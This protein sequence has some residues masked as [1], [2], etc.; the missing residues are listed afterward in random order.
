MRR[1]PTTRFGALA[2]TWVASVAACVPIVVLAAGARATAAPAGDDAV[3]AFVVSGV[4]NGHGRG[5][6]Q[7]GSFG[8][9]LAG[10]TYGEILEAYYGNTEAGSRAGAT[11][12][13][14]L[15]GW[16]GA[17]TVGVISSTGAAMWNGVGYRSLMAIETSAGT[18]DVYGSTTDQGCPTQANLVVPHVHLERG[19]SGTEVA[20]MQ[21]VL[22]ALGHSPGAIDGSFGEMTEAAVRSFQAAE[23]LADTG[24]WDTATYTRAQERVDALGS[25]AVAWGSLATGVVG[26]VQFTTT[27]SSTGAAGEQLGLCKGDGGVVHYRGAI[28]VHHTDAGNRV[29]NSVGIDAY[30]RGVVPRESPGYWGDGGEGKGMHSLRAQSVAA[31][32]YA[33]TQARYGSV[34]G[35]CDTASCQVYGGAATRQSATSGWRSVEHVNTDQAIADTAGEVRVWPDGPQAG[36]VVSTEFSASNGP[37]TAGGSFPAVDDPFDDHPDNPL[38]RWTRIIDA[39]RLA[40]VYDLSR[41]DAVRTAPQPSSPYQGIWANEV[42]LGD[43]RTVSAWDFRNAFALPAPGFELTPITRDVS[44]AATFAYIGDSVG[45]GIAGAESSPLRV[46][47]E[48]VHGGQ[49]WDSRG[50]RATNEGAQVAAT[51]PE[52]TNL[53]VVELGYNDSPSQMPGRI[54]AVM[55]ALRDR[56]VDRVMWVTVSERRANYDYESTNAAIR[57][58]ESRWAELDVLEWGAASAHAA[59][60][61]WYADD[62]VHLT[63]TGNAEFSLFLRGHILGGTARPVAADGVYRVPVLGLGGVPAGDT[64]G[65]AGVGGVALNVTAVNPAGP[66]WLRVWDCAAAEPDTSSVNFM[67]AGAVEPNA[68]VVPLDPDTTEVCVRAKVRTHVIVDVAGYFPAEPAVLQS[69]AGRVIDTRDEALPRVPAGG[70]LRVQVLGAAGVPTAPT[71][72]EAGVAGVA[73]NV[74]A[75]DTGGPGWLRVWDCAAAEPDTSSVNYTTAGAAE[76]NAVIVPFDPVSSGEVCVKSLVESDVIV[77]LAGWF[78]A[79]V[80]LA[81][82]RVIDTRLSEPVPGQGVLRVPVLGVAGVPAGATAGEA[83]VAGV[84]LNVT[85]VDTSAAG[86]LRVWDCAR[87]E[88]DTSS[89]NYMAAGAVEPNAVVVPFDPA[90]SGEVCVK[91]LVGAHVIVD[92]AGWFD[93]GVAPAA[94][95]I[96]DTRYGIGPL[97]D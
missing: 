79:G 48:G 69:A 74:T 7:W 37:R 55:Q 73:L 20:Q 2:I 32:S 21:R 59:A 42:V 71:A 62:G 18:F 28:E 39:D 92:L 83:G 50:G 46:L 38:H 26:P 9:A 30:L 85:A 96:A 78:S 80:R 14:R 58:A 93:A 53:A 12:R 8:R 88:P 54:D 45:E 43:G 44:S 97:P 15:T 66:G 13:V 5:L 95:R 3:V 64:A 90:G 87:P 11:V 31:R 67:A 94:G 89:V 72:G 23:G 86:W 24:Q 57:A 51:V 84:A 17:S 6:S 81:P 22:A 41:A 4:G 16:D 34:A 36:Q 19:A 76:P 75:V 70:V 91:T 82:G 35:T 77:D 61:R 27:V 63:T 40:E 68:V 25:G 29:V 47:L 65:D 56:H 10:Q 52:G 1:A 49:F 60:D 33:L